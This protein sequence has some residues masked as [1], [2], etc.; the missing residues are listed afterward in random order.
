MTE[1][2]AMDLDR[3]TRAVL[4]LRRPSSWIEVAAWAALVA[5]VAFTI[6]PALLGQGTFLNTGLLSRYTPWGES[7]ETLKNS[8]NILSSDTLDSVTPQ[9]TLLVRL[10]HE[11]VFGAWNPYVAGGVEL[12]GVPNSGAWSPLSLP[13]WI[14]PFTYAAGAV[15]LLEIVAVT[16]GM[17]LL[18][19]RW[20]VPRAAWPIASLVFASS[21]FM[22]AWS[23]WPQ[24]RVAAFI[25][26]LF[27]AIDRAAV[28]LR[29]RDLLSVGLVVMSMLLGGFPAVVGYALFVGGIFFLARTIVA[30][31]AVRGVLVSAGIAVGGILVGVLLSAWQ[32]IPFAISASNVVDF[33]GRGQSGGSGLGSNPMVSSWIPDISSLASTG[34]AWSARNPVEEYSYLGIG[35]IVLI[36]AAVLLRPRT[37]AA[38]VLD[39]TTRR[40][41]RGVLPITAALLAFSV[42]LVFLGGPI[43]AAAREL[44]VFDSNPIGR[45]RVVVGFFAAVVAGIG[46][47]RVADP[48]VLRD[49]L[50]RF[51]R[52]TPMR[53]VT[54]IATVVLV[55]LFAAAVGLQTALALETVPTQYVHRTK[56]ETLAIGLV[57]AAV[58]VCVLAA[59]LLRNR[60]VRVTAAVLVAAGI[61][62]PAI[63]ATQQWWP[64]A[65]NSTFYPSSPAIRYLQEHVGAQDRYATT[66]SATLPGSASYYG[67]RSTTGHAFQTAEWKQLMRK[68]DPKTYPTASYLTFQPNE[69]PELVDSAI[70]DRV[71]TKYIVAD[72]SA[73]LAGTSEAGASQTKWSDLTASNPSVDSASHT[74]PVNGM[75]ITGPPALTT[76]TDGMTLTV[77]LIDD[78]TGGTLTSTESW[79][80]AMG[81]PRNV[82]VEGSDIPAS[83]S[84]HARITITGQ[85]KLVPIGT[86]DDGKAVLTLYRP[87]EGEGVSVVHT[88]DATIY[89]RDTA[90][91]RVRWA[92]DQR[93]VPT[94]YGRVDTLAEHSLPA[95]TVVLSEQTDHRADTGAD[96]EVTLQ[97]GDTSETIAKVDASGAGWLVVMDSVQRPGWHATVDGKPVD[98]VAADNAGGAVWV[99][100]GEH[101]VRVYYTVPRLTAGW[102]VTGSTA[103]L[104]VLVSTVV[105]VVGRRRRRARSR[106]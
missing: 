75:T 51:R 57:G 74:G 100:E 19:R 54:R 43:L 49:E 22:V 72:P 4:W 106:A 98:L 12:G 92:S 104:A 23:N 65:P 64:I 46:F 21:G 45:A 91:D 82:A 52:A 61:A 79:V 37:D 73:P 11:G 56:L 94:K 68:V 53:R 86:D 97:P 24:T 48:E 69:I 25:P 42:V 95:D 14:L 39:D 13:W 5:F 85:S 89:E 7:L 105:V 20:G 29:A 30:H 83:T 88:G 58:A 70:L 62:A 103:L 90:L 27:W 26:L 28:E 3:R 34:A 35:A 102:L 16:A 76:S 2:A 84:W 15:K 71:A 38:V 9:T 63:V 80:P 96:A 32:L 33:N 31:R 50:A 55:V 36:A 77:S 60:V 1:R 66:G 18:L 101:T 17:S 59:W 40:R 87:V 99:P 47:G 78:A 67:I 6:G 44:P 81:G 10:A 8:T 93:V 41:R